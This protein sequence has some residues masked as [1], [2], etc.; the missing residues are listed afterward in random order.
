MNLSPLRPIAAD[1]IHAFKRDGVVCLRGMFDR[2]WVERAQA[3]LERIL[4]HPTEEGKLINPPGSPGRFE[5]DLFMWMYDADFRAL[6]TQSPIGEIGATLLQSRQVTFLLDMLLVKEPHTPALTP[7]HHDQPYNWVDGR[8]V[9]GMWL[10]L[11]H[12]TAESGAAEWIK[13]SHKWGRWFATRPFEGGTYSVDDD[14]EPLPDI[15]SNRS[16]YDIVRF[17]TEP[18]DVIVNHLLTVHAALGNV[19]SRRRRAIVYRL[20][21][22]DGRFA[23][24][25]P[26][27]PKPKRDPG[28]RPGDP[29]PA[30]H[31][32][33]LRIWPRA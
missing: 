19:S 18:G 3:A 1:E 8:Q 21:G 20:A 25:G 12:V 32:Q 14:L 7:W 28:L 9:C 22:D 27:R 30:N 24:R 17:D 29:F 15:D 33:F 5:R 16:S 6:A 11:D 13:G 26:G 23:E 31:D 2:E 10:S 4:A